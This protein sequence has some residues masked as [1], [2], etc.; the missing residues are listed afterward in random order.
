MIDL[1]GVLGQAVHDPTL[2]QGV[3][4]KINNRIQSTRLHSPRAVV[5][6]V[7]AFLVGQTWATYM[8]NYAAGETARWFAQTAITAI[9]P[10]I[11]T[12][13]TNL[14]TWAPIRNLALPPEFFQALGLIV[15]DP[16]SASN[17]AGSVF[18]KFCG[19]LSQPMKDNLTE[20]AN[21]QN[22]R[23]A[24]SNFVLFLWDEIACLGRAEYYA[25]YSHPDF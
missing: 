3:Q 1:W 4:S 23:T 16:V 13:Q 2:V 9:L 10:Q 5:Q 21:N 25:G 20:L 7:R 17:A 24:A 15:I 6:D 12:T 18:P 11:K 8:T 14:P 22:F 19:S